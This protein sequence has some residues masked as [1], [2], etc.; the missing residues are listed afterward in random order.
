MAEYRVIAPVGRKGLQRLIA[1]LSNPD[2]NRVPA[3]AR[4][5]FALLV[6]NSIW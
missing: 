5:S 6:P 1:I 4:G 2:D 3:M